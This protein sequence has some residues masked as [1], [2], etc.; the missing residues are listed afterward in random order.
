MSQQQAYQQAEI[1]LS[2]K[3]AHMGITVTP[4]MVLAYLNQKEQ[5]RAA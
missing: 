3:V 1:E 5:Q 2:H 4:D